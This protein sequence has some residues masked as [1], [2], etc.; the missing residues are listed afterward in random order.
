MVP[1]SLLFWLLWLT[2]YHSPHLEF[3]QPW[4]PG[5]G[6]PVP[7]WFPFPFS[8]IHLTSPHLT[9]FQLKPVLPP[10]LCT[11][12][13]CKRSHLEAFSSA[14][15]MALISAAQHSSMVLRLAKKLQSKGSQYTFK[16]KHNYQ[17]CIVKALY[18]TMFI[19]L[20]PLVYI[21][22]SLTRMKA[23]VCIVC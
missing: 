19:A 18:C 21:P 1:E 11:L 3:S 5:P 4:S 15:I 12:P 7:L 17:N 14:L 2:I 16:L 8:Y 10:Q 9:G 22:V 20:K 13:K 23:Q 6:I